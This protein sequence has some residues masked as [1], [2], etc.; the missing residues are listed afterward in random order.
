[1]SFDFNVSILITKAFK[2]INAKN[3]DEAKEIFTEVLQKEENNRDA[4][5]GLCICYYQL[6][7]K[8]EQS[9]YFE[10]ARVYLIKSVENCKLLYKIEPNHKDI[11]EILGANFYTLGC[12]YVNLNQFEKAITFLKWS[13]NDF[14]DKKLV[15]EVLAEAYYYNEQIVEA[16]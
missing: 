8:K 2:E 3:Y 13:L 6:G 16:D 11:R 7:V 12:I 4:L 14:H 5:L 15:L 9:M 1:M 10:E